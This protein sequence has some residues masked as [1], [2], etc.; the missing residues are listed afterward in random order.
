MGGAGG[1]G[2]LVAET[3]GPTS[4]I[5]VCGLMALPSEMLNYNICVVELEWLI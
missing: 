2:V 5:I 1:E 4:S 3:Y